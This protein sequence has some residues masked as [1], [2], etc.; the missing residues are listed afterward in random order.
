MAALLAA[1]QEKVGS[2]TIADADVEA[3]HAW[4]SQKGAN[5]MSAYESEAARRG[6]VRIEASRNA[7]KAYHW[8]PFG[9]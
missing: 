2:G 4:I 9:V 3:I 7:T 6:R 8:P 5:M 1:L